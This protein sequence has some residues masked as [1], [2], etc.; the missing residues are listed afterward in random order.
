MINRREMITRQ[1]RAL[2]AGVP[3]VNYG[4]FLAYAQGILPRT[5]APLGLAHLVPPLPAAAAAGA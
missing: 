5:L 4:V 1:A 3:T 2:A